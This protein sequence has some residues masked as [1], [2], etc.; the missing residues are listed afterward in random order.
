MPVSKRKPTTSA[1]EVSTPESGSATLPEQE[2]FRQHLR[3][4]VVL[5]KFLS[6]SNYGRRNVLEGKRAHLL[7]VLP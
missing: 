5:Q 4:L 1:S 7:R 2:E 6:P 3:R